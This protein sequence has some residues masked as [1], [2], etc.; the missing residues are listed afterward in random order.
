MGSGAKKLEAAP[1]WYTKTKT[2]PHFTYFGDETLSV[3]PPA[4]GPDSEKESETPIYRTP[5]DSIELV[6]KTA[7]DDE[8]DRY[9]GP[10]HG[11]HFL[12]RH[13]AAKS[14]T[15]MGELP[16]FYGLYDILHESHDKDRHFL[17]EDPLRAAFFGLHLNSTDG[18]T[19]FALDLSGMR[20]VRLSPNWATPIPLPD[21][22]AFL[23]LTETRYVPIPGTTKTANCSYMERW[24]A[25]FNKIRY[26]KEK[27]A[28][29]CYGASM[30]RPGRTPAMITI[31]KTVE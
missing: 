26:A 10:G 13:L 19:V 6:L 28:A 1:D 27:S 5:D 18:D 2:S 9:N 11:K 15:E 24:D 25:K 31:R 8:D 29:V 20:L 4:A 23:T 17:F 22:A 14:Q 12:V 21:Q 30:Y 16:G 3:E 7:P